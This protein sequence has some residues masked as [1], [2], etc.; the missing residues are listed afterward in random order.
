M[1]LP[2]FAR[3]GSS[4]REVRRFVV[5]V[6][7]PLCLVSA[8][9]VF[10]LDSNAAQYFKPRYGNPLHLWAR[11]TTDIASAG[12]YFGFTAGLAILFAALLRL[13]ENE[14]WRRAREWALF[15]LAS[16]ISGGVLVQ[17]FKHIIGRHRPYAEAMMTSQEFS[18][19]TINYEYHSLPSGHSQV[20]FSVAAVLSILWPRV[21]WL[22][23]SVAVIFATTRV[24]TLNHWVSDIVAGAAVGM[25]GTVLT[26][27]LMKFKKKQ[28]VR[29]AAVAVVAVGCV[30]FAPTQSLADTPGPF[31]LGLVIGDPTGLSAAYRISGDRSIDA[32]IAW[33]FGRY[34]GFEMHG[35][36]LWHRAD[37]FQ[38]GKF[39]MDLHY[40]IG[41]RLISI[42]D[43]NQRD[44][45]YFGPR[46]PVGLSSNFNQPAL[47]VF[48]ELALVMNLIPGTSADFDFGIGARIYF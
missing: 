29:A 24:I 6:C 26:F 36:Y 25:L 22:W 9:A 19:F 44:R 28:F 37:I 33:N 5:M 4:W 20:L 47:E 8:F 1:L 30:A 35:D 43:R 10:F 11:A 45:T 12:P 16:L 2:Y 34:P 18:P 23:L 27:R 38:A 17:L 42:D 15:S 21:R 39:G 14:K 41:A 31:G 48:A 3:A 32:A 7:L 40:G 13:T 46:L